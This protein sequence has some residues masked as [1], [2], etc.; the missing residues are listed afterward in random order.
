M[1]PG[2]EQETTCP[3]NST[4]KTIEPP[5]THAGRIR[6]AQRL[7][8]QDIASYRSEQAGTDG[9]G[10]PEKNAPRWRKASMEFLR[11]T[12]AV[13]QLLAGER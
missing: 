2:D 5:L 1:H 13:Q 9:R 12:C 11:I 8:Q 10:L 6:A 7:V 3:S 4:L